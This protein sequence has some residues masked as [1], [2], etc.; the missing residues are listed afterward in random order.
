MQAKSPSIA[1]GTA[2]LAALSFVALPAA[3]DEFDVPEDFPTIQLAIA[4]VEAEAEDAGVEHHININVPVIPT[5]GEIVLDEDLGPTRR[6][7]IRPGAG[8]P[9]GMMIVR[10]S[11]K[12]NPGGPR[13]GG[14]SRIW[15]S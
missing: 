6:L 5:T 7:T 11:G 12:R 9:V 8:G 4:A 2:V 14:D 3:A 15:M 1:T 10:A 13:P